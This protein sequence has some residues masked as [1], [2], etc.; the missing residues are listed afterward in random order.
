MAAATCCFYA[1][2][3]IAFVDKF[4]G[5]SAVP[6]MD[7]NTQTPIT[8]MN[9]NSLKV[10]HCAHLVGGQATSLARAER[11]LGSQ[12]WAVSWQP[13][14]FGYPADEILWTE[15]ASLLRQELTRWRLL[16]RGAWEF[17]VIHYNYGSPILNWGA[18]DGRHRSMGKG[19]GRWYAALNQRIEL[20]F[21]KRMRK[22]IA[23][24]YQGDDARQGD[25]SRTNFEYSIAHEVDENYY[26]PVTDESK[27]QRIRNF[28]E[29]ADLIYAANPDLLHV[30][31]ERAQFLPYAHI[32]LESWRC[33]RSVSERMSEKP[34]VIHAPSHRGAKGTVY[35]LDA[36]KQLRAEGL[37]FD[38]RLVE[39]LTQ[40]EARKLYEQ[41]D[42]V[43]DQL[44]AGW[45]GGFAVEAMALE[46]PVICYL[47]RS[48][49]AFLPAEMAGDLPLIEADPHSITSV[50]RD[51]LQ[52]S[53]SQRRERGQRGRLFVEKWHN[54]QRIAERL[55]ADY[56]HVL[57]QKGTVSVRY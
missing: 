56:Q 34:L 44:L 8:P 47:R 24:T 45:Y 27:R 26:S 53:P 12:S 43:V 2:A 39:G 50:L 28:S 25:F 41:A 33:N 6:R 51:W 31:P 5:P 46:K 9:I 42:I 23:V 37:K 16:A 40:L 10:L 32:D 17:D 36:I 54:P 19:L 29:H 20:P 55:L 30:L 15:S 13:S 7:Q 35:V 49:F 22:V 3:S 38:F 21:I 57:A 14:A 4:T 18:L 11:G 48:D 52:R 1:G